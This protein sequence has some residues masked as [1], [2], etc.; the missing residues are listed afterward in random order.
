MHKYLFYVRTVYDNNHSY[1]ILQVDPL[2]S[3]PRATK[4]KASLE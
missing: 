4:T 1:F 2:Q 3:K